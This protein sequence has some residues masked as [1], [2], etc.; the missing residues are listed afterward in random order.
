MIC[1]KLTLY[2]Y[3]KI[4]SSL[5]TLYIVPLSVVLAGRSRKKKFLPQKIRSSLTGDRFF[6]NTILY[7]IYNI[8]LVHH[9]LFAY[10]KKKQYL[11]T[12]KG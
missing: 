5:C 1:N 9:F 3:E 10:V 8:L 12:R 2:L 4:S 11:C 7:T 6:F